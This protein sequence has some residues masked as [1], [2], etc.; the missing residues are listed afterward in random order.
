MIGKELQSYDLRRVKA[1]D[2]LA[3]DAAI[4]TDAHAYHQTAQRLHTRAL[5]GWGIV[6]GLQVQATN[7]PSQAVTL[8]PG[9]A[10]DPNGNVIRVPQ[11]VRLMVDRRD[12]ETLL[13]VLRFTEAPLDTGDGQQPS[14]V[15]EYFSFLAV[16]PPLH[17]LDIEVARLELG[18]G[19]AIRV[20]AQL[21]APGQGEI[22]E[23]FRRQLRMPVAETVAI[24]Q[25]VLAEATFPAAHR[26]GLLNVVREL[27][28]TAPFVPHYVG[29]VR[30]EEAVGQCHVLYVTGAGPA[31]VTPK[32]GAQ[33]LA[34][35]RAGGVLFAEPCVGLETQRQENGRFIAT[36]GR[37]LS[38]LKQELRPVERTHPLFQA[39][40]PFGTAPEGV[41]GQAPLTGTAN[42]ILNPNDYGCLWQ[43]G[44]PTRPAAREAIRSALEI[45]ANLAWM[46]AGGS[47]RAARTAEGLPQLVG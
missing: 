18:A 37:I 5:H 6:E 46:A 27:Q 39:R 17:P 7:P 11:P 12:A 34:F 33:L 24:G 29:D 21:W 30:P 47:E 25:L 16:P 2:G 31:R 20:A 32:E 10:I 14:R 35:L 26:H 13:L 23:R 9:L 41:G 1:Y 28:A 3:I 19:A 42:V 43:G 4:W 36:F 22:D 45:G 38:E 15:R 44:P 8:Q 40:Y